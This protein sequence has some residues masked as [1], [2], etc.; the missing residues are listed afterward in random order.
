VGCLRPYESD[1]DAISAKSIIIIIIIIII[2]AGGGTKKIVI[3][4]IV[5]VLP[6]II[7]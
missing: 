3:N 7:T 4:G 5:T 1:V 2:G 6:H